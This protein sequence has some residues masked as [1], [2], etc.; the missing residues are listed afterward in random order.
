MGGGTETLQAFSEP[1]TDDSRYSRITFCNDFFKLDTF[2][3]AIDKGNKLPAKQKANLALWDNR[4]RCFFHEVT[5]LDHFM[6]AGAG[7][8]GQSPYVS[9]L[10]IFYTDK[11]KDDWHDVYSP[12]NCRVR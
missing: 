12:Y 7:D 9:D 6:N 10:E 8:D 2:Q 1:N 11:G 4:A 3:D 5:H